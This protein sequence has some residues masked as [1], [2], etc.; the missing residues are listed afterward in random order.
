MKPM[1][2]I[3]ELKDL[4][5]LKGFTGDW[6]VSAWHQ[7]ERMFVKKLSDEISARGEDGDIELPDE[8]VEAFKK[9]SKDDFEIDVIKT[10]DDQYRILDVLMMD[11]DD[12]SHDSTSG[13]IKMLRGGMEA[14]DPVHVPSASDTKVLL[15]K[16]KKVDLVV[17]DKTGEG[18]YDYRLGIG[19]ITQHENLDDRAVEIEN[20]TYMDVGTI[21]HDDQEY[22]PGDLV[23][24]EIDSVSSHERG[25][26]PVYTV[27]GGSISGKGEG[28]VVSS[29]TLGLLTKGLGGRLVPH[30]IEIDDEVLTVIW[31]G[32]LKV[33]VHFGHPWP[34]F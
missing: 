33:N 31:V 24:V 19:P 25:G 20:D 10:T 2:R 5:E 9:V 28:A 6:V 18:P 17:L 12:V 11:G 3:F 26:L 4:D 22:N 16:S 14:V 1:H 29:E 7:G 32:W 21:F 34:L 27:H 13:R 30:R 15:S 23:N 8:I